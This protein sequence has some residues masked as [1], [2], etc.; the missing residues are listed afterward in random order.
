MSRDPAK[1]TTLLAGKTGVGGVYDWWRRLKAWVRGRKFDASHEAP[2][3][4][5]P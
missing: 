4:E 1:F 2:R 3:E 5:R